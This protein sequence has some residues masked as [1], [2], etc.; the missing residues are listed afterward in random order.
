MPPV[1][2]RLPGGGRRRRR[3][4]LLRGGCIPH[5]CMIAQP[6]HLQHCRCSSSHATFNTLL[7]CSGASLSAAATKVWIAANAGAPGSQ[8][9]NITKLV[10]VLETNGGDL[11]ADA[12]KWFAQVI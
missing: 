6:C 3:P 2:G 9:A 8:E 4:H 7:P 11:V 10:R 5:W 12:V 1:V